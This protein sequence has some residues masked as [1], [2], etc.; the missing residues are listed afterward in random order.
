MKDAWPI[1]L[2]DVRAARE[3]LKPYLPSTPLRNYPTLDEELGNG[4]RIL[5]KHENHLPTNAFKVRNALSAVCML[6]P[7][8]LARGVVCA[9]TGNH[10]QGV[11]FA[12]R[13]TG[14]RATVFVPRNNNP[15][16]NAAMR[17]LGATVVERGRD[18]DDA[19]AEAERASGETGMTF[20]HSTNDCNVI[21]GAGTLM[22]EIVEQAERLDAV[23]IA[24]GGGSQAV[25]A[26][27]V[28]R[29]VRPE[30][31]VYGVQASGANA[32][33]QSWKA[34]TPVTTDNASTFAEGIATRSVYEMTWPALRDGLAGFVA[35]TDDEIAAAIR[36]LLRHTQ[37]LSEGAGAAGLAGVIAL[38]DQL[39]HKTVAVILS[40]SNI[41]LKTL[42]R[43]LSEPQ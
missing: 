3:R 17:A 23:A 13:A 24:I 15:Q 12:A 16:K 2:E 7:G 36:S 42:A 9:S 27:T 34:Q 11:A 22:L 6:S 21:A 28:L 5:V 39:A 37:N 19:L 14:A 29:A 33:Y 43:V 8:E 26:M 25:G 35:V 31:K 41:E 40:G 18:Y 4:C 10:G 38:R 1:T 20:I 32:A 30:V